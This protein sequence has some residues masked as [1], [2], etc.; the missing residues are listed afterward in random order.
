VRGKAQWASVGSQVDREWGS[1]TLSGAQADLGNFEDR[2][3]RLRL[4]DRA[5]LA[6]LSGVFA[7]TSMTQVTR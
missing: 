4:R 3:A 1:V 7:S 5:R 6:A 2:R